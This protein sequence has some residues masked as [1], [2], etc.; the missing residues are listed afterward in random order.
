M[1]IETSVRVR[2][3]A[4]AVLALQGAKGTPVNDLRIASGAVRVWTR[5]AGIPSGKAKNNPRWMNELYADQQDARLSIRDENDGQLFFV[6][7]PESMAMVLKSN[8]GP[9][10]GTSPVLASQIDKFATLAWIEDTR[11]GATQKMVRVIDAWIYKLKI[12]LKRSDAKLL[13]VADYTGIRSDVTSLSAL[14]PIQFTPA[15]MT[16]ADVRVYNVRNATFVRDPAG[17]PIALDFIDLEIII[18]QQVSSEWTFAGWDVWK[19][20]K[21]FVYVK[22]TARLSDEYWAILS[23]NIAGTKERFRI[24]ATTD[25]G[26]PSTLTM[27]LFSLDW[28]FEDIGHDESN[29]CLVEATGR[30]FL[31]AQT[32]ETGFLKFTIT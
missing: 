31:V 6:A 13:V 4:A 3:P 8:W 2:R 18:D 9:F 22:F 12:N 5:S 15:P 14:G 1:P 32:P 16:P 29:G 11:A 19:R 30:A 20:G 23:A 27:D 26:S 10:T 24:T 25:S 21:T 7:T 28:K 17:T